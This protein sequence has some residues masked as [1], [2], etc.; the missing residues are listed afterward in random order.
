MA[1]PYWWQREKMDNFSLSPL[2]GNNR[3]LTIILKDEVT[4]FAHIKVHARIWKKRIFWGSI[5][6]QNCF[7]NRCIHLFSKSTCTNYQH[8]V[9]WTT[10]KWS[11]GQNLCWIFFIELPLMLQIMLVPGSWQCY[12]RSRATSPACAVWQRHR[13]AS[14]ITGLAV[15]CCSLVVTSA[16]PQPR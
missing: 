15:Q 11:V 8:K 16:R 2:V 3:V 9:S 12:P 6:T 4:V 1:A 14:V 13:H 5:S 7:N 10:M